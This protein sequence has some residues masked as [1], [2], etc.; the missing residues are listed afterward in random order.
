MGLNRIYLNVV[1]DNARANAF[2]KKIGFVFEGCSREEILIKGKKHDLNWY[3]FFKDDYIAY[4]NL[5]WFD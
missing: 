4:C 2:Y 3:S 1:K 5:G